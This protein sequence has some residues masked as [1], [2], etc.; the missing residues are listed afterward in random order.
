MNLWIFIRSIIDHIIDLFFS[1][2]YDDS[3]R[4]QIPVVKE[5]FLME[6]AVSLAERIRN[7]EVQ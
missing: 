5:Y 1:Y 7:K 4:T 3:K 6:S 2:L